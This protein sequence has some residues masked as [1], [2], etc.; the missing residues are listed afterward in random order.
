[1]DAEASEGGLGDVDMWTKWLVD[2]GSFLPVE[3]LS[4]CI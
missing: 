4:I 2:V 3:D 1:M